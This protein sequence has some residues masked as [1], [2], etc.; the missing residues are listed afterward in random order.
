MRRQLFP[1][2]PSECELIRQQY[3]PHDTVL[4]TRDMF[5]IASRISV[6]KLGIP[7]LWVFMGPSQLTTWRLG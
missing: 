5:D 4:V 6:E 7:V 2:V 1:K 3:R